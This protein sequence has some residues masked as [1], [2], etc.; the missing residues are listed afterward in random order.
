MAT[1]YFKQ[2]P[3]GQTKYSSYY[4]P[5]KTFTNA[6]M[7]VKRLLHIYVSVQ[8]SILPPLCNK[9]DETQSKICSRHKYTFR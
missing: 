5:S 6:I 8:L 9:T 2:Y 7:V 1:C 4:F 3:G